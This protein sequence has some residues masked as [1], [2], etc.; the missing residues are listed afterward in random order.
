MS[1]KRFFIKKIFI[2]RF[3][4][5]I[6]LIILFLGNSYTIFK[7]TRGL[8]NTYL[9]YKEFK[10]LEKRNAYVAETKKKE[11]DKK[12]GENIIKKITKYFKGVGKEVKR[13][14]WTSGRELLKYSVAAIAFVVFF[15]VYFYAIDWIAL[16]IRS[17]TN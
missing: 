1:I 13:I 14:K 9:G 2:R 12:D 10:P 6:V 3:I 8:L 15:A 7:A 17:L 16:I 5:S 4:F 11:K